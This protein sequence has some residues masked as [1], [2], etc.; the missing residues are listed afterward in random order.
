L[1]RC[2]HALGACGQRSCAFYFCPNLVEQV[3]Q[4]QENYAAM[5]GTRGSEIAECT[6]I[7]WPAASRPRSP[8]RGDSPWGIPCSPRRGLSISPTSGNR[9]AWEMRPQRTGY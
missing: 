5:R 7:C 2:T 8:H 6:A 9:S 3:N 1:P 4:A